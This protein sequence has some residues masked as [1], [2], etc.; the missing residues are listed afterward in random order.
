MP[1]MED[2]QVS[3]RRVL[4]IEDDPA[5]ADVFARVMTS[6]GLESDCAPT[7]EAAR[8]FLKRSS[9]DLYLIDVRLSDT[10]M[11]EAIEL[12]LERDS[13]AQMKAA[14]VT[15]F[16]TLAKAFAGSLPIIDKASLTSLHVFVRNVLERR[17]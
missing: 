11:D 13:D 14:V 4:I 8:A 1:Q 17:V 6:Y 15:A 10:A 5:F 9:Y 7:L 2:E 16:P 3:R 12:V